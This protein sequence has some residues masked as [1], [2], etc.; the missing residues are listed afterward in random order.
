VDGEVAR[1]DAGKVESNRQTATLPQLN[2]PA[3]RVTRGQCYSFEK[4]FRQQN[5]GKKLAFFA[6]NTATYIRGLFQNRIIT[7]VLRK[8]PFPQKIGEC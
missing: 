7:P 6:Q 4:Y 1:V 8:T 5:L 2:F 3:I